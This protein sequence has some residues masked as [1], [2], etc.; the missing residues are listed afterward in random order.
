MLN[1]SNVVSTETKAPAP[2]TLANTLLQA[3]AVFEAYQISHSIH[4]RAQSLT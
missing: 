3:P 1:I 4:F 2:V